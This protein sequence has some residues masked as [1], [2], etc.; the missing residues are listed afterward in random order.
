MMVREGLGV[1]NYRR[2][3]G[4][5]YYGAVAESEVNYYKLSEIGH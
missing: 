2:N 4:E 1:L 3:V 5:W